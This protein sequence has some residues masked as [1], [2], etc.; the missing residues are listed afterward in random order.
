M[1]PAQP[2]PYRHP[3][4]PAQPQP[5]RQPPAQPRANPQPMANSGCLDVILDDILCNRM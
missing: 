3:M 2:Q 1:Q 4:P 5:Y